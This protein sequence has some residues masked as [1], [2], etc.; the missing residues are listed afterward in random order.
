MKIISWN[1]NSIRAR[2]PLVEKLIQKENPDILCLQELKT[3]DKNIIDNFFQLHGY[4]N[5]SATQKAYNGV[6]IGYKN[7]NTINENNLNSKV[8]N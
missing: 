1:V 2:E 5:I 4:E 6:A 3:E 7:Q 8:C